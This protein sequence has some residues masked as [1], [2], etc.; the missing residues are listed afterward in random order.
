MKALD[1]M[2]YPVIS[3][4]PHL[5]V[6]EAA[7]RMV[8]HG[9]TAAPVVTAEGFV[10]GMVTEGDLLRGQ[11]RRSA[12]PA[13]SRTTLPVIEIMPAGLIAV[14][15]DDDVADIAT[16]LLDRGVRAVAVIDEGDHLLGIITRRD[17]LRGAR[18]AQAREED[19]A[20]M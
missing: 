13:N 7:A 15:P 1:V 8:T 14:R 10:L 20:A 4:R 3:I 18:S 12:D 9:F 19:T 2:S 16:L 6:H 17:I 5:S 11:V